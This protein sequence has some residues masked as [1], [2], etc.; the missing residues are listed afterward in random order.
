M[1]AWKLLPAVALAAA[2]AACSDGTAPG[3]PAMS[4]AE[5]DSLALALT[6]DVS[7]LA[8]GAVFDDA[9]PFSVAGVEPSPTSPTA[10][11][12]IRSP[13]PPA[14][15][16]DDRVPDSV[17]V[18]YVDCV[19]SR[20]T[21]TITLDGI[22]DVIDPTPTTTDRSI[23]KVYT[24]FTRTR[25]DLFTDRTVTEVQNGTRSW[26]GS[27]SEIEHSEIDFRT[28]ITFGD[29]PTGTHV[30]NWTSTFTADVPGTIEPHALPSGTWNISGTSTWTRGDRTFSLS[31]T[32][33]PVLH[34]NAECAEAPK[35]DAGV[36]TAVVTRG[37]RTTTVTIEYSACGEYTVTRS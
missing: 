20:P 8:D 19:I 7:A 10:C 14:N 9:S 17:R 31:V 29:G 16:D 2:A 5:A 21:V 22:I 28:D 24:D 15:S 18:E 3:E 26:S 37:D 25:T 36:L 6:T 23:R 35:F 33:D 32:T 13:D 30:R 1:R 12:P 11:E 27:S 4:A 34:Y